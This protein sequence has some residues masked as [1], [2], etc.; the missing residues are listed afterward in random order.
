MSAQTIKT[1]EHAGSRDQA[2]QLTSELREDLSGQTVSV[3][4][5]GILVS[6]PSFVD[7]IVKQILNLRHASRLEV[8]GASDRA[9]HL[10]IRAANN[11]GVRDRLDVASQGD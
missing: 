2:K 7:E 6:T 8:I 10:L 11:R 1:P 3:D 4:F 9:H 5:T